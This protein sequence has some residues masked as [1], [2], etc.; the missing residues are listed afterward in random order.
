[1]KY[2]IAIVFVLALSCFF[3]FVLGAIRSDPEDREQ[4]DREQIEYLRQWK[5]RK[6]S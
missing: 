1:M 5:Q 6:R 3:G 4:E 2:V